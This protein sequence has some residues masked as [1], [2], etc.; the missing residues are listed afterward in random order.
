MTWR[1]LDDKDLKKRDEVLFLEHQSKN[2][3]AKVILI[4]VKE[5]TFGELNE[6]DKK[7]HEEFKNDEEM[8]KTYSEYYKTEINPDTLVKIIRFKILTKI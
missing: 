3:F 2:P 7:G 1:C 4:E 8:Y 6:E 5:K